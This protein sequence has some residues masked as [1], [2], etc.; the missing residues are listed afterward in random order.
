MQPGSGSGVW[1]NLL[2]WQR[3]RALEFCTLAGCAWYTTF[4]PLPDIPYG[5]VR[6]EF[7]TWVAAVLLLGWWL[8][9]SFFLGIRAVV[10]RRES[11][12]R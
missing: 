9:L 8:A 10:R 12:H 5:P 2:P 7:G 3:R 11:S 4:N 6:L 1:E